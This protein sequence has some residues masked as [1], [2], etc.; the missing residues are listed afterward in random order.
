ML[1]KAARHTLTRPYR[2]L[3]SKKG[4]QGVCDQAVIPSARSVRF[5]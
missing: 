4:I 3:M 2:I 5:Q 1:K